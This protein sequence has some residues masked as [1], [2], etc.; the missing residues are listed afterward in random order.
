MAQNAMLLFLPVKFNF[1][2]K[3]SAAKFLCV[4]TSRGKVV[5]SCII[6]LSDNM[7]AIPGHV[8]LRRRRG[9]G[10]ALYVR[11]TTTSQSVSTLFVVDHKYD[12]LWARVGDTFV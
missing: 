1:C 4:K 12:L 10:V 5:Y 9:D 3:K 8:L 6:P 2:R 7:F 11:T